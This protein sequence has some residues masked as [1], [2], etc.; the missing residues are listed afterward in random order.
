MHLTF[1][2]CTSNRLE[3]NNRVQNTKIK[4]Y[5][6]TKPLDVIVCLRNYF[7]ITQVERLCRIRTKTGLVCPMKK[8]IEKYQKMNQI[9]AQ[10]RLRS[11]K[12]LK[13]EELETLRI[14]I[15]SYFN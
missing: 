3:R 13:D 12:S 10:F 6:G 11:N 2:D 7:V 15:L 14:N 1:T 9:L 8:S 5:P 4:Q